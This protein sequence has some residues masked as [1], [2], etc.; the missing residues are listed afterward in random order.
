MAQPAVSSCIDYKW[1]Y[2]VFPSFH[3][4]DTRLSFV[5][6]LR[7]SLH[8]RGIRVFMD[9]E[10]IRT[11]EEITPALIKAIRESRIAIIVFSE[12][13]ANSTFCLQELVEILE[14]FKEE[15]RLIYPV[16]YYV[17]PSELRRPRAS[18]AEAL[19]RLEK[20]FKD[21]KQQVENWRLALSQAANLKGCH[22][23][24]KIANEQ[25]HITEITNEVSAR[26]HR[27]HNHLHVTRYP[28]G[29]VSRVKKVVSHLDLCSTK[30]NK[31]V[32]IV[33]LGGIG[34]STIA[35]VLYNLISDH[36]EGLCFL[37]DVRKNSKMPNGL[38]RLQETLLCKLVK[39]KDLKL[40]DWY[41]GIP[42]I[43][44]RL[45]HKKILLVIDDVD[46]LK[47]LE[48]LA[49]NCDWFG[50]GSRIVITTRD[51]QLLVSH[52]VKSIYNVEELNDEESLQL[53]CWC[54]FEKENVEFDF[55]EVS[56]RA[57]R[58]CCG[59]PLVLEVTGSY[60]CGR[61]V[62][63]WH[64]ALD[65]FK[66]IPEGKVLEVLRLS[67]DALGEFEKEIFLHLACF[68]K[69]EELGEVKG[70]LLCLYGIP[71]DNVINVLVNKSLIRI[72]G[73]Q[74]LMHDVI[75]DMGKEIVRQE[76]PDEPGK[77]SRLWFYQDILHVLNRNTGTNKVGVIF[78]DLPEDFSEDN[79]VQ[80]QW[81]GKAFM[82]MTNLKILVIK[83][84]S[85]ISKC[86]THLPKSLKWLKWKGY[87]FK[88]LPHNICSTELI[89]LD[90]SNSCFDTL[91]PFTKKFHTLS[92]MN[93]RNCQFL[94]QIPDLSGVFNLR[95]LWLDDCTNLVEIHHSVGCL[96]KLK[97]LSAMR[98][99]SLEILLPDLR[100]VSLE[101]LNLYG[102]SRLYSF[103]EILI[104]M[105]YMRNLHLGRTAIIVLPSS[106]CNLIGLETLNIEECPYLEQLPTTI[107]LLP[108]LW[109]L[110]ATSSKVLSH[111]KMYKEGQEENLD[112]YALSL[113][114]ERFC[115][116]K[117]NLSDDSLALCLSHFTN[118]IHLDISFSSRVTTLPACIKECHHLK[119]LSLDHCNRLQHIEEMPPN[120]EKF[121]AIC[122]MSL[123]KRSES[124]V[125]YQVLNLQPGK[126]N[127]I[128]PG[129]KFPENLDSYS[130][131]SCVSFWVRDVFP[132]I[133]IWILVKQDQD[134]LF[135]CSFLVHVNDVKLD[136]SSEWLLFP[137]RAMPK[138]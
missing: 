84:A 35:R 14:C 17:D 68:S 80:M 89:C 78:L 92:R 41:E 39:E 1:K 56:K 49:G 110:N 28:V 55:M 26:I 106:I 13:Y 9:D 52:H 94:Q 25:E 51:K 85:F 61:G 34:K 100:L 71:L 3:G 5:S 130:R 38:A 98:C 2:D 20:R 121:S 112:C 122:C 8:E 23:K 105:K 36:F 53:L 12:N 16:F 116:S 113:K 135:S 90:L 65:Q 117:C 131:R 64:S 74:V 42:I 45:G 31:M 120:L 50:P 101:N 111:I 32:G 88:F 10:H 22:L 75:E 60:L 21:N 104:E 6:F 37:F 128:F 59:L 62:N 93:F 19:A 7:G 11:G 57:I 134:F 27:I 108:N 72:E 69:G 118:M 138:K 126:T 103:P 77:R 83:N 73:D 95:E 4:E 129:G 30:K 91:Q 46:E 58:Y 115:F 76:S 133:F 99:N 63:E 47:Q 136:I 87:P 15:G 48:A 107:C 123:T 124:R 43:K 54:A 44:H 125:L 86:P 127:F 18:Y 109:E 96:N 82:K 67:Y 66:R 119:Y 29:L 33:G 97:E 81:S 132:T 24:A 102:C 114:L 70:M 79:E 137:S 40:G